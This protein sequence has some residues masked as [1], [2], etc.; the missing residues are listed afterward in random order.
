[1]APSTFFGVRFII[2]TIFNTSLYLVQ[3]M[4]K[5]TP[6]SYDFIKFD[7]SLFVMI[8]Y[9]SKLLLVLV[10]STCM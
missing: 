7:R 1:M 6:E 10:R 4:I 5:N 8:Y 9:T 2:Y 3:N